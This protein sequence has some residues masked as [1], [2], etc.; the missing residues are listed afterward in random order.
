MRGFLDTWGRGEE[1]RAGGWSATVCEEVRSRRAGGRA[2]EYC[3]PSPALFF[4]LP[5]FVF[6]FWDDGAGSG[7]VSGRL[8][9]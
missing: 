8:R 6:P 1:D 4:P 3:I 7:G 9:L 5:A 2:D